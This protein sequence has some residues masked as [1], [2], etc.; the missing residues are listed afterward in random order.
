MEVITI[1]EFRHYQ[2]NSQNVMLMI[3]K[4]SPALR[5]ALP[6]RGL[7]WATRQ[8]P[9]YEGRRRPRAAVSRHVGDPGRRRPR[10]EGMVTWHLHDALRGT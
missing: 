2:D 10:L 3:A 1:E 8:S 4:A 9:G 7:Q 5:W 6:G